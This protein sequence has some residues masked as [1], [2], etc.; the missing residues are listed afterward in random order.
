MKKN[1]QEYL[2]TTTVSGWIILAAVFSLLVVLIAWAYAGRMLELQNVTIIS[3]EDAVYGC[4][5]SKRGQ[6][7]KL[8]SGMEVFFEDNGS[9]VINKVDHYVYTA[10][11]IK[12]AFGLFPDEDTDGFFVM[13]STENGLLPGLPGS[14]GTAAR[15]SSTVRSDLL[16]F[17]PQVSGISFLR[18]SE[19]SGHCSLPASFCL[20]APSAP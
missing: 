15:M 12:D 4:I 14:P 2:K 17:V 8:K 3:T 5:S 11:E 19:V 10:E 20:P 1:N 18:S 6:P 9:G 7:T 13:F 16:F